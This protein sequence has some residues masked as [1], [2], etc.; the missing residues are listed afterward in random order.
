MEVLSSHSLRKTE[1]AI[2]FLLLNWT[3]TVTILF[4][5]NYL[6]SQMPLG[7]ILV[8]IGINHSLV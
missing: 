2:N 8:E 3:F 6:Q 4:P 7:H 1:I 5:V